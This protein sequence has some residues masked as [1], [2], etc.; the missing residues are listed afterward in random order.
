MRDDDD[1]GGDDIDGGQIDSDEQAEYHLRRLK[2]YR[3]EYQTVQ[4]RFDTEI[5]RLM[6]RSERELAKIQRRILWHEG[7]LKAYYLQSG[8]KRLVLA[9]ATL[10]S[11]KGRERIEV[12]NAGSLTL[13]AAE[14]GMG[15][16]LRTT[17]VPDKAAIM[18]YV[19]NT[20]EEPPGTRIER[21]EDAFKVKF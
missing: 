14:N 5:A 11:S 21:G 2:D 7:G 1:I 20:G 13:W 4:D 12:D 6:A 9:N 18:A 15:E 17:T 10:S 3:D 8:Q 19:K 16:L